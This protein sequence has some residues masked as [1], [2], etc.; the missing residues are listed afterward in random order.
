MLTR[1][2]LN[3]MHEHGLQAPIIGEPEEMRKI[4]GWKIPDRAFQYAPLGHR[5]IVAL[6]PPVERIGRIIVPEVTGK[7]LRLGSG[8]IISVGDLVGRADT[9]HWTGTIPFDPHLAIGAKVTFGIHVG[10]AFL[11]KMTDDEFDSDVLVINDADAHTI[12]IR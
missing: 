1:A 8:W 2:D 3:A 5:M 11:T 9:A 10:Y 6:P 7:N 12:E 4:C